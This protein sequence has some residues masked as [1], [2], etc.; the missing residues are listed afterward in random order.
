MSPKTETF[1][2][3]QPEV[4]AALSNQQPVVALESTLI[5]HGLPWPTNFE[6]AAKMEAQV[7]AEG[8]V[9]ATIAIL[10]G[11]PTIGL[12]E[13]QLRYL[14][15]ETAAVK[16]SVRDLPLI[17]A[18]GKN[19]STTVAATMSLALRAGIAVF[20]TGGVGGVHRDSVWDVSADLME[21][22]RTPI[23]VVS[24]GVKG[25]L[26]LPATLE[27]LE[28]QAVSV[29]GYRTDQFP[30]FYHPES[31]LPVDLRVES[32]SEAVQVIQARDQ[33][34]LKNAILLTVPVPN[35]EAWP[36]EEAN[37]II[38]QA[39][40]EAHDQHIVGKAITP[41]LL[42]R[43]AQLSGGQSQRANI[44]LLLNNASVGAQLATL[45]AQPL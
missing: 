42:E 26:D 3:F 24:A 14:A 40:S 27:V 10:Q 19:G 11:R 44:A 12:S 29:L 35:T 30:A 5:T 13:A 45:L 4:K 6:I 32:L 37:D 15:Q 34:C 39:L 41:F 23:T 33:L 18:Q 36:T 21:L 31:N 7:R 8:A 28:T 2:D 43:I 22:G 9:P 16:C 1:F 17:C 38:N 25:F 20:A